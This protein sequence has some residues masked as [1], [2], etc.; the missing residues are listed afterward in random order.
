MVV[1]VHA[2]SIYG[3]GNLGAPAFIRSYLWMVGPAG[4]DVFFVISGF[5]ISTVALGAANHASGTNASIA[6]GFIVKRAARIYPAYWVAL[7]FAFAAWPAVLASDIGWGQ[8]PLW[9]LAL[10]ME[11]DNYLIIAAWTLVYEMYFYA[12]VAVLLL[13]SPPR[14]LTSL[15]VW[16]AASMIVA[17]M[18]AFAAPQ[19]QGEIPLSPMIGEFLLGIFVGHLFRKGLGRYPIAGIA[20]GLIW[21]FVACEIN[22]AYFNYTNPWFR[23]IGFGVGAAVV[24]YGVLVVERDHQWTFSAPWQRLGDAS[25]SIYIWH[26]PIYAAAFAAVVYFGLDQVAPIWAFIAP[27]VLIV[28]C[29]GFLSFHLIERPAQSFINN[30]LLPISTKVGFA[31]VAV[32]AFALAAMLAI[33]APKTFIEMPKPVER[34]DAGVAK[35]INGDAHI[36][37]ATR[38]DIPKD[39]T[40]IRFTVNSSEPGKLYAGYH[41]EGT[42]KQKWAEFQAG[43]GTAE[44]EVQQPV[45]GSHIWLQIETPR[46]KNFT[47]LGV[48]AFR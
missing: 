36:F 40:V 26:Q 9:R 27:F 34:A 45:D 39:A 42:L 32:P 33:P 43:S 2:V 4:V 37:E 14:L 41:I 31:R 28:L 24:V 11:R 44:L 8:K 10:L 30:A 3:S 22:V 12:V 25:Y 35:I 23:L 5:I 29:V 38:V 21:F 48:Q 47:I 13:L 20:V 1:L 6:C 19:W 46:P 15:T 18:I 7:L 16:G 17:A